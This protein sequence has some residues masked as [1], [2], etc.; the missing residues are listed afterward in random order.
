[1]G[2]LSFSNSLSSSRLS[3]LFRYFSTFLLPHENY[4]RRIAVAF[5]NSAARRHFSGI[6][7]SARAI[8]KIIDA[9]ICI[10]TV[11]I[12]LFHFTAAKRN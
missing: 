8:L 10:K 4:R 5:N 7:L 3:K 12:L 1:M 9:R 2:L 6:Y 11:I